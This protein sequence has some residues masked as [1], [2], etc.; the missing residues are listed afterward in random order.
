MSRSATARRRSAAT[1]DLVGLAVEH[2]RHGIAE[3]IEQVAINQ[4][5]AVIHLDRIE[6]VAEHG[7]PADLRAI[8]V[9][10][11]IADPRLTSILGTL[12]SQLEST[13]IVVVSA[14]TQRWAVR[15]ALTHGAA[16]VIFLDALASC[17]GPCLQAVC[18]GQICAPRTHWRQIEPPV[19]STREKQILGL[20]VMGYM[21]GQIAQHL[22]VAESTVKSHLSSAFGKLG[23]RSRNEAIEL[24]RDPEEGL[25]VGILGLGGE[26][27]EQE[28]APVP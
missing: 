18:A 15:S 5:F 4:G 21:N 6:A 1:A 25:G 10:L 16:G 19:L 13:P 26:R 8:I 22:F 28:F 27:V 3:T 12:T 9:A 7:A 20:V 2:A 23:V 11:Q 17:L 24:I 14:D